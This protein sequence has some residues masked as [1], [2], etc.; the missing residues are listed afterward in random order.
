MPRGV[1]TPF[2][3]VVIFF[4]PEFGICV[5]FLPEVWLFTISAFFFLQDLPIRH[6]LNPMHCEKNVS[7]S[8]LGF[9]LEEKDTVA[10]QRDM[11]EIGQLDRPGA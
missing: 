6:M 11:E 10:V 7:Q 3:V 8:M 9:I 5:Q 4:N 2:E 1:S